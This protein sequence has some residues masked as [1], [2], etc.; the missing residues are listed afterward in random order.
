MKNNPFSGSPQGK[1]RQGGGLE[2]SSPAALNFSKS[3]AG[4]NA[5]DVEILK[6]D[7]G[8]K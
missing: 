2:R 8:K 7:G 5:A 3:K 6:L 1:T 4:F